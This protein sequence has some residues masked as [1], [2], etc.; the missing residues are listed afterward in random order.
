[1]RKNEYMNPSPFLCRKA[2]YLEL[3]ENLLTEE[4]TIH[5]PNQ[6]WTPLLGFCYIRK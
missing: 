6:L 1:M 2:S 3:K 4:M 5:R